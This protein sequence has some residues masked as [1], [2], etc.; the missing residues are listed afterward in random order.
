MSKNV[1]DKIYK[2]LEKRVKLL[3]EEIEELTNEEL[4]IQKSL[5]RKRSDYIKINHKFSKIKKK[6]DI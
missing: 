6:E 4:V 5:K 1:T 2:S 3:E